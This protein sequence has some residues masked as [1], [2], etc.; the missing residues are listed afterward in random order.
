MIGQLVSQQVR[1]GNVLS[2]I[3]LKLLVSNLTSVSAQCRIAQIP[4][5]F[6]NAPYM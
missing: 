6:R 2:D 1:E 3:V 4:S 5:S